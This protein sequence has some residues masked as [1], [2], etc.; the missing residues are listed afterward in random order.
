DMD[1][2]PLAVQLRLSGVARVREAV[3]IGQA[4]GKHR[5]NEA[6]D[7]YRSNCRR[8]SNPTCGGRLG[9]RMARGIALAPAGKK[10]DVRA[11]R[12]TAACRRSAMTATPTTANTTATR[13]A[14]PSRGAF[15]MSANTMRLTSERLIA[16]PRGPE[17][18]RTTH[19]ARA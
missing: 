19:R 7:A 8:V 2:S 15:A 14:P 3:R 12:A 5:G 10:R 6:H 11:E 13:A 17:S 9:S 18:A 16:P 1:L 4:G